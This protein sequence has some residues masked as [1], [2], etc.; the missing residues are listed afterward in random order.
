MKDKDQILKMCI[1]SYAN[2]NGI[3]GLFAKKNSQ[4]ANQ[5]PCLVEFYILLEQVLLEDKS[6]YVSGNPENY[7]YKQGVYFFNEKMIVC[8]D[9]EPNTLQ[10]QTYW[11]TG[12]IRES[13]H[14]TECSGSFLFTFDFVS[15]EDLNASFIPHIYSYF[16]IDKSSEEIVPI[17]SMTYLEDFREN[18]DFVTDGINYLSETFGFKVNPEKIKNKISL[19]I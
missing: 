3:L 2:P 11:T 1:E 12:F 9:I 15:N 18:L 17:L 16:V 19:S 5:I 13:K 7:E 14:F 4:T 6:L 8:L 10:Y